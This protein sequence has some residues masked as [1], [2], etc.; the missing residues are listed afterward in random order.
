MNSECNIRSA[1]RFARNTGKKGI[2]VFG[3][4]GRQIIT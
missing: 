3:L 2:E 4:D 1:I